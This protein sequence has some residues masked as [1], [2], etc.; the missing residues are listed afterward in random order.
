MN[1]DRAVEVLTLHNAWRRGGAGMM[2]DPKEI[3]EAIDTVLLEIKCRGEMICRK[4][5]LRQDAEKQEATF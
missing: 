4:C 3:G 2:Q 5:G 1:I